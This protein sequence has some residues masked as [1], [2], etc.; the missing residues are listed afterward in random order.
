MKTLIAYSTLTGNTKKIANSIKEAISDADLLDISEV[1]SLDYDLIIVGT[2]IDKGT[3]DN[4]AINF[5]KTI[6]DK[7]A[8]FFFTLGAA[9]NSD[10]SK[11]CTDKITALFTE[12]NNQVIGSYHCQGA[13]DPKLIEQMKT[14]FPA[15]HHHGANPENLKRWEAASTHPDADDEKNAKEY[16]ENLIKN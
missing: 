6:K 4:K 16:F 11:N 1:K 5:I 13:I 2:W 15:G 14:M 8:A 12:N 10:H 9:A 7:K 3:A